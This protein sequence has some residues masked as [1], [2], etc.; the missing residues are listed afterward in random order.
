M[1]HFKHQFSNEDTIERLNILLENTDDVNVN[2]NGSICDSSDDGQ[3]NLKY[4]YLII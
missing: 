1:I 3:G 2:N 4:E